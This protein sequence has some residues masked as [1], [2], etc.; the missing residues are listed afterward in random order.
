MIRINLAPK[1]SRP[2]SAANLDDEGANLNAELRRQ[3]LMKVLLLLAAPVGLW[4]YEQVTLPDLA[5]AV[6]QNQAKVVELKE[7]NSKAAHSV[8][9][10]K[11][12]KEDQAKIQARIASLDQITKNRFREIK[13]LDLVQQI[14]P[15]K[16]WLTRIASNA[17]K[18]SLSGYA[19]SDFEV[20]SFMEFLSK[21]VYF[22]DVNLISSKESVI[23]GVT[24]KQFDIVCTTERKAHE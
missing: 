11:G 17:G 6:R 7:Y 13:I 18:F 15:E 9:E 19:V 8:S 3:M 20:S 23:D 5:V 22:L 10:I 12:F 14:I 21:S 24:L 4:G 2:T 1:T 16:V